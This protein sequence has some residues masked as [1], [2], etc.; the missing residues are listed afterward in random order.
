[1]ACLCVC[2][3]NRERACHHRG[4]AFLQQLIRALRRPHEEFARWTNEA[5][6]PQTSGCQPRRVIIQA[7]GCEEKNMV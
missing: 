4:P 2:E 6:C 7:T 3:G 5:F 1:M